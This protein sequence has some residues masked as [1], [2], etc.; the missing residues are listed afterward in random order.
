MLRV[1]LLFIKLTNAA[2][3]PEWIAPG[4]VVAVLPPAKGYCAAPAATEV[5]T[6]NG[7]LCVRESVD[8]VVRDINVVK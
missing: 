2:G 4:Q 1:A 6:L 8:E 5:L 7:T 3:Q